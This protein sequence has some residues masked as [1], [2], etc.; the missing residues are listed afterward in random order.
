M[1]E[2]NQTGVQEPEL[3]FDISKVP[4]RPARLFPCI[5]C[6]P[7]PP[8]DITKWNVEGYPDLTICMIEC[9]ERA[10]RLTSTASPCIVSGSS[11]TWSK[12]ALNHGILRIKPMD[13][14]KRQKKK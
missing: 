14:R 8:F 4:T 1:S 6:L 9:A 2:E 5:A 12:G 3:P 7:H 13:P 10:L 11:F